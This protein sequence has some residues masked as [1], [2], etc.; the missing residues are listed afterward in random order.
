MAKP[1]LRAM[2][3]PVTTRPPRPDQ[4]DP[5]SGAP[6]FISSFIVGFPGETEEDFQELLRFLDEA[7]LNHVGI[8]QYSP[9]EGSRPQLWSPKYLMK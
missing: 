9:E 2:G 8:F 4:Q 3:R 5:D 1:V 7:R 6:G